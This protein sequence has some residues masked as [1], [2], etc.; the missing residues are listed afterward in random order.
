VTVWLP[1]PPDAPATTTSPPFKLTA[2][3]GTHEVGHGALV[4]IGRPNRA[5]VRTV[6]RRPVVVEVAK[7]TTGFLGFSKT[8]APV[9][10]G[11]VPMDALLSDASA[12]MCVPLHAPER[13]PDPRGLA[14]GTAPAPV[15]AGVVRKP[16]P[17]AG[18]AAAAAAGGAGDRGEVVEGDRGAAVVQ[19]RLHAPLQDDAV[20]LVKKRVLVIDAMPP[21]TASAAGAA[22]GGVAGSFAAPAPPRPAGPLAGVI[23]VPTAVPPEPAPAA[24]A[25][26][27]AAPTGKAPAPAPA[28]VAPAPAPAAAAAPASR[29][30]A[31]PVPA[32]LSDLTSGGA[33]DADD[34]D[35][36][37][38]TL[39]DP[40]DTKRFI[41]LDVMQWELERIDAEMRK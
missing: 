20:R 7:T 2:P 19:I 18:T 10:R 37:A 12:T 23:S 21:L 11:S 38:S 26:V 6:Q 39:P 40:L 13:I 31:A 1:L 32:A 30:P 29:P 28:V 17:A 22:V 14:A 35:E 9:A 4:S 15:S 33:G 27:A 3:E 8:T 25:P 34:P 16:S 41:S 36:A 24:P 5:T